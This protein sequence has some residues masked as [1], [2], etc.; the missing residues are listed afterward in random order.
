[1]KSIF[2][3]PRG[4]PA[5]VKTGKLIFGDKFFVGQFLGNFETASY[6]GWEFEV[7]AIVAP[8]AELISYRSTLAAPSQWSETAA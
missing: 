3:A 5:P 4:E 1:M 6:I 8:V 7:F 2:F